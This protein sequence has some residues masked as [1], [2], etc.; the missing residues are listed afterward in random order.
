[1]LFQERYFFILANHITKLYLAR[2]CFIWSNEIWLLN[3][4]HTEIY[5]LFI[6]LEVVKFSRKWHNYK[7]ILTTK[8]GNIINLY[9]PSNCI[10]VL[11]RMTF[12]CFMLFLLLSHNV[13]TKSAILPNYQGKY[14]LYIL[15]TTTY[16]NSYCNIYIYVY[17]YVGAV[18]ITL[19]IKFHY[20]RKVYETGKVGIQSIYWG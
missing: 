3:E 18:N 9:C 2:L 12:I 17:F 4:D 19:M 6:M 16:L 20:I 10:L 5:I 11:K 1:M 15:K 14:I 13:R 8:S 7:D